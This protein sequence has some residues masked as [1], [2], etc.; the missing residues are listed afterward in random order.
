MA[1]AIHDFTEILGWEGLEPWKEAGRIVILDIEA[2]DLVRFDEST[3]LTDLLA[4][5]GSVAVNDWNGLGK[6]VGSEE[7]KAL[8]KEFGKEDPTAI[9]LLY[10]NGMYVY[11]YSEPKE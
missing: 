8:K 5:R 1:T 7:A 6:Q 2:D 9:V 4:N 3:N 11:A 10:C